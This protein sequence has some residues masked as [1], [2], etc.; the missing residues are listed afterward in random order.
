MITLPDGRLLYHTPTP[1]SPTIAKQALLDF[2][3]S[4]TTSL[5]I[6]DYS[7]NLADF[8]TILPALV[9]KGVSVQLVLDKSQSKGPTEVP[10][11]ASLKASGIDMVIGTSSM[12]GIIHD[13]FSVVDGIH[14]E[15]G[16]FNYTNAAGKE[17]NF[18]FIEQ[19]SVLAN[20]LLEVGNSIRSWILQNEPMGVG[21]NYNKGDF[22]AVFKVSAPTQDQ[23]IKGVERVVTVFVV[24]AFGAWIAF[25]NKFTKAA[26]VAAIF[27]GVTA[28]YQLVESTLTV[29]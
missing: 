23:V 18:F 29:I 13:K 16:S 21:L 11:I 6:V 9:K 27:A 28:V 7:F 14:A 25:P 1:D 19:N 26:G 3:N 10:I 24:A 8:E 20:D 4:A 2:W 12:H 22:M 17:D 5:F 15:Y